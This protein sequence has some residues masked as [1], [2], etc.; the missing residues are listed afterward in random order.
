MNGNVEIASERPLHGGLVEAYKNYFETEIQ[1]DFDRV[2]NAM[3]DDLTISEAVLAQMDFETFEKKRVREIILAHT[4][5]ERLA[6]YLEW[7]GI[8]GYTD[9]IYEISVGD[10]YAGRNRSW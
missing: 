5:R 10:V 3:A 7:N 1:Q 8:Q 6:V 4:P 2:S 9:T